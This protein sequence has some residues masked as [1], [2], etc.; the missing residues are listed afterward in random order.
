MSRQNWPAR[1]T[2]QLVP[3][4]SPQCHTNLSK[5]KMLATERVITLGSVAIPQVVASTRVCTPAAVC[6]VLSQHCKVYLLLF[7][8]V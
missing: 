4:V 6:T 3:P 2:G 5:S 8:G 1:E 7:F